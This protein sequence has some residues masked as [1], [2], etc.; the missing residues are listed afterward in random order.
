MTNSSRLSG[1]PAET[2]HASLVAI[3]SA[4]SFRPTHR[5]EPSAFDA[6]FHG[7]TLVSCT[8]PRKA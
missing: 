6:H 1:S 8:Q 5:V 3:S 7:T 2:P 4:I